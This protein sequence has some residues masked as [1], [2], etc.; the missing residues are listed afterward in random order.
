[1]NLFF[2]F[3]CLKEFDDPNLVINHL[4][5]THSYKNHCQQIKC[6]VKEKK[7]ESVFL[8]FKGLQEHVKKCS[9]TSLTNS[10]KSENSHTVIIAENVDLQN[11]VSECFT[12]FYPSFK[13]GQFVFHL[14]GMQY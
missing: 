4:K 8:T 2:C 3:E 14:S 7:C 10:N 12:L 9:K 5:K 13:C 6:I 1:M 11:A